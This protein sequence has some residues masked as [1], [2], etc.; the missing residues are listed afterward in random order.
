MEQFKFELTYF[1][2]IQNDRMQVKQDVKLKYNSNKSETE[3]N[4]KCLDPN[5]EN[6]KKSAN[7]NFKTSAEHHYENTNENIMTNIHLDFHMND[8]IDENNF[9]MTSTPRYNHKK[10][11]LLQTK[12]YCDKS[13]ATVD[14]KSIQ[15]DFNDSKPPKLMNRTANE[16]RLSQSTDFKSKQLKEINKNLNT[17]RSLDSGIMCG[18]DNTTQSLGLGSFASSSS[19]PLSYSFDQKNHSGDLIMHEKEANTIQ[20]DASTNTDA[21]LVELT[22]TPLNVELNVNEKKVKL[23][24]EVYVRKRL[25]NHSFN[26]LDTI[27]TSS[28][29]NNEPEA[30]CQDT[31]SSDLNDINNELENNQDAIDI[32]KKE[33]SFN[34]LRLLKYFFMFM[35][36]ICLFVFMIM[37]RLIP[38]C[39]DFKKEFLIFNEKNFNYDDTPLPF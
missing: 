24:E 38:T 1:N 6:F 2:K 34:Y 22:E 15:T 20:A 37:P 18:L 35:F 25:I 3:H 32:S 5:C 17:H 36:I 16:P 7:F 10:E 28:A 30:K 8:S 11:S 29:E 23:N 19:S 13:M 9:Q 26:E 33:T 39:C 27:V 14:D 31:F 4:K 12:T 21:P